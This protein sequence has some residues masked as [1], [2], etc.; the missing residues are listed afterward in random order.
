MELCVNF[1]TP[2]QK[3]NPEYI[4]LSFSAQRFCK[5]CNSHTEVDIS[6]RMPSHDDLECADCGDK[7]RNSESLEYKFPEISG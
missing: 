1:V 4:T 2:E 3:Q 5:A 6:S 7:V